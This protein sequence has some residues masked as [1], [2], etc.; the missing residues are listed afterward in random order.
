[1]ASNRSTHA[2]FI[3]YEEGTLH[4]LARFRI[5]R[6]TTPKTYYIKLREQYDYNYRYDSLVLVLDERNSGEEYRMDSIEFIRKP[7]A[8]VVLAATWQRFFAMDEIVPPRA[9]IKLTLIGIVICAVVFFVRAV[10]KR[11]RFGW[12][13]FE[14]YMRGSGGAIIIGVWFFLGA[15]LVT[16]EWVQFWQDCGY[17]A[18]LD[19][20]G[21]A[22]VLLSDIQ[23]GAREDEDAD[24]IRFAE[25]CK[26][27]IPPLTPVWIILP[28]RQSLQGFA[29]YYLFPIVLY[30]PVLNKEE[31]DYLITYKVKEG[32]I[33]QL[34]PMDKFFVYRK[35][36][37]NC[38]IYKRKG[39]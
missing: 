6:S 26:E 4:H 17:L 8:K 31:R 22:A 36:N 20:T 33:E 34:V 12:S 11:K 28:D 32:E 9:L 14:G 24:F 30:N 27:V 10:V 5:E 23:K 2:K 18:G 13:E 1:M 35:P 21:R 7:N 38:V 3:Y 37:E 19:E 15:L 16:E 39:R 29:T 25:Y